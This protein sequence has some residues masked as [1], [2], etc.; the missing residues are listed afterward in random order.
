MWTS[1]RLSVS[2][3]HIGRKCVPFRTAFP[4]SHLHVLMI[5][6]IGSDRLNIRVDLGK[7]RDKLLVRLCLLRRHNPTRT[8]RTPKAC[9]ETGRTRGPSVTAYRTL[10]F[11]ICFCVL[12]FRQNTNV[13]RS[14]S[15]ILN[16]L[17]MRF[18]LNMYAALSH[19]CALP[20]SVT[21]KQPVS[22]GVPFKTAYSAAHRKRIFLCRILT[23]NF[24]FWIYFSDFF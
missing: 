11:D 4:A 14:F 5:I 17:L 10:T 20:A 16:K 3:E 2:S 8:V 9:Y 1:C 22:G 21:C 18:L 19:A 23:D 24:D 12:I 6:D 7:L 15:H 13:R